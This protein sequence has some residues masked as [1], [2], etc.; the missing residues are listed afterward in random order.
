MRDVVSEV[1]VTAILDTDD[2]RQEVFVLVPKNQNQGN[3]SAN[4][5][6]DVPLFYAVIQSI[7]KET[8][9]PASSHELT[10]TAD[11]HTMAQSEFGPIDEAF[12]QSL[13]VVLGPREVTWPELTPEPKEGSI[14]ETIVVPNTGA[15]TAKVGSLAALVMMGTLLAFSIWSYWEFK[16]KWVSRIEV[17]ALLIEKKRPDLVVHVQNLPDM[18]QEETV[19]ELGSLAELI[20]TAD[21][22]FKPIL[23]QAEPER[24]IY[25]VIDGKARYQYVSL[26][27]YVSLSENQ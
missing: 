12:S 14:E 21:S 17:D 11:V 27:Q 8:G 24:H 23:H 22:L 4:F 2:G 7:E 20:K 5:S 19:A 6:L 25:C 1:E 18:G 3:F 26:P 16:H 15:T 10:V 13:A 9:A